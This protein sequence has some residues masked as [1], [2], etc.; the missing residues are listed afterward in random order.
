MTKLPDVKFPEHKGSDSDFSSS[1]WWS[2]E[3]IE[4]YVRL[5]LKLWAS[6]SESLYTVGRQTIDYIDRATRLA[7]KIKNSKDRLEY[8][9]ELR[10]F[11]G[12]VRFAMNNGP[13]VEG[14]SVLGSRSPRRKIESTVSG[15]APG[16]GKRR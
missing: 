7:R 1:L 15:G 8:I 3:T 16:L 12:A 2:I 4:G 14:S 10:D 5:T 9:G 11:K 13:N 6:D